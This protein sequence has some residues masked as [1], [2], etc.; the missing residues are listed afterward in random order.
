MADASAAVTGTLFDIQPFSI[1]DGP[2]IR[3][4]VFFKG[5]PLRC[6]WCH[7]PESWDSGNELFFAPGR[8]IACGACA[9]SC[10][11]SAHEM[12]NGTHRIVRKR[13]TVC[14]RCARECPSGALRR[15][16]R[17]ASAGEILAEV[18]KDRE[19]FRDSGGG[20][21][22]SGGE[23]A[24][25]P[26]LAAALLQGARAEGIHTCIETC[27]ACE[28]AVLDRLQPLTD[29]FLFDI[30]AD[31][32]RHRRLT[33]V[34]LEPILENLERLHNRGARIG[35]RL[36]LI[37]GINDTEAHFR[38]IAAVARRLT[39]LESFHLLPYHPLAAGKHDGLGRRNPLPP[40]IRP[41]D[42]QTVRGW[43]ARLAREGIP[44]TLAT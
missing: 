32:E 35:L 40:G 21:T 4:T 27:G 37:P 1:H 10:P 17:R 2:G 9:Q 12:R 14:G 38:N 20:M 29:L 41:P 23:P 42:A 11:R 7:N 33:G 30:K 28:P 39:S 44:A 22:L 6:L 16:G 5:C 8:C 36:P 31:P 3:T 25:Q 34:P 19:F 26:D 15:I 18:M 13:C 43:L 24:A